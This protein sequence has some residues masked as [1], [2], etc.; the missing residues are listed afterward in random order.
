M[1]KKL[2]MGFSNFGRI[3]AIDFFNFRFLAIYIYSQQ[4][5]TAMESQTHM[6][7]SLHNSK[8]F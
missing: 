7:V 6:V 4:K 8:Q 2:A 1:F 3:M 5:K